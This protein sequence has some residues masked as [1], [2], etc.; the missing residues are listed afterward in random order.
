MHIYPCK[1]SLANIYK[2]I[3]DEKKREREVRIKWG[4]LGFCIYICR[5]VTACEMAFTMWNDA[6][7]WQRTGA[8]TSLFHLYIMNVCVCIIVT[9]ACSSVYM[10]MWWWPT[11]SLSPCLLHLHTMPRVWHYT[12]RRRSPTL[13]VYNV[14]SSLPHHSNIIIVYYVW[15]NVHICTWIYEYGLRW[16][17]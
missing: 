12:K 3:Y 11:Q 10:W 13:Y 6:E 7:R 5:K 9:D 17:N 14:T 1:K 4:D 8:R 15:M 2:Y 16:K